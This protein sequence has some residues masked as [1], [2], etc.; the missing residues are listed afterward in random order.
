MFKQIEKYLLSE[1]E[2]YKIPNLSIAISKGE[3]DIWLK[4]YGYADLDEEI[5]ATKETIYRVASMTKPIIA[6]ALLQWMDKG[7]FKLADFANN[8][9]ENVKIQTKFDE[10]P[11]IW[12]LLTHTSGLPTH[13]PPIYKNRKEAISL[14][15]LIRR[16]GKVIR[17]P[18]EV[19]VYS[20]TAYNIIGYL[21]GQFAGEPYPSYTKTNVLEPLEMSSS[22]FELTPSIKKH[23]VTGY[24]R[25]KVDEPLEVVEPYVIGCVPEATSSSLFTTAEDYTRFLIAHLNG[26]VYKSKRILKEETT[27]EMQ[28]IHWKVGNSRDG[29]GLS[30]VVNW[31]HGYR[32]FSHGGGMPGVSTYGIAFPDLKVVIVMLTSLDGVGDWRMKC[33]GTILQM[34]LGKYEPFNPETIQVVSVPDEWR[35]IVG[36]YGLMGM[37]HVIHIENGYLVVGEGEEKAYLEK[38]GDKRYLIHGSVNDGREIMFEY[39]KEGKVKEIILGTNSYPRYVEEALPADENAEILGSWYGEYV[40]SL[41]PFT[42]NLEIENHARAKVTDMVGNIVPVCNFKADK[43][44]VAGSFKCKVLPEYLGWTNNWGF[45]NELEITF[46]LAAI[47]NTL[48]GYIGFRTMR[49]SITLERM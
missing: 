9:L 30:W 27:R 3:D 34:I 4:G 35:K 20:N 47:K 39:D 48:Q 2:K 45:K 8:L 26:G 42:L 28:K 25:I 10:Q 6:T 44:I 37:K 40:N 38:I 16:Y 1:M 31:L 11:T 21:V 46:S 14:E 43:G 23:V 32:S 49:A 12:N 19:H 5:P 17:P 7:M 13:V 36:T 15:E 29:R 24:H 41:H 22:E 18:N 33:L